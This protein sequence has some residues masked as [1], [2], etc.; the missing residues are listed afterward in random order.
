MSNILVAYFSASGTT[1]KVAQKLASQIHAD[2]FKIQPK[3]AYTRADLNWNDSHSRSTLEMK[4]PNSRPEILNKVEKMEQYNTVF[5]GFPIWWYREPS[6]IDTFIESYDPTNKTIIPFA[7]SG[8]SGMGKSSTYIQKLAPKS[9]VTQ[10]K[11]LSF[12]I[13]DEELNTWASSMIK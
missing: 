3:Q 6:I 11:R 13:T 2:L 7:T 12:S 8:G 5:V 9:K 1:E 10:G 4:D